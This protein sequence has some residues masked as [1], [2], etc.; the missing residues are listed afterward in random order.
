MITCFAQPIVA[1]SSLSYT[2]ERIDTV[3]RGLEILRFERAENIEFWKGW[4]CA[5]RELKILSF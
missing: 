1:T 5:L 2:S 4:K 3:L